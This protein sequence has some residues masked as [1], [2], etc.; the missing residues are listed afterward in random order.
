M[1]LSGEDGRLMSG[2]AAVTIADLELLGQRGHPGTHVSVFIPAHRSSAG[3][4]GRRIW[5]KNLLTEVS[6]VPSR[7]GLRA[8][9]IARLLA[10]ARALRNDAMAGQYTGDGLA[11]FMRPGWHRAFR[12]PID[13]PAVAAV[14]DYFLIGPLLRVVAGDSHFLLLALSRRKIRLFEGRM[15]HIEEIELKDV[16]TSLRHVIEPPEPRSDTM[17]RLTL[18]GVGR[19]A[20]RAVFY[21]HGAAD[22]H[23]KKDQLRRFMYQ[24]TDG[25]RGGYLADQDLPMVPVG[26]A[27][28]VSIYREMAAYP[29]LTEGAVRENPDQ[30][31]AEELHAA[32][33][34][35]VAEI[36][37]QQASRAVQRFEE[38]HGTGRT[39]DEPKMIE[40]AARQGR[41]ETLLVAE[42]PWCREQLPAGVRVVQL[43]ADGAFSHCELLDRAAA[44]TLS[45]GGQI[46]TPRTAEIPG[47]SDIAAVFRYLHP[48]DFGDVQADTILRS[49]CGEGLAHVPARGVR[50]QLNDPLQQAARQMSHGVGVLAVCD[51]GRLAG[52]IS[53]RDVVGVVAAAID[54]SIATAADHAS[55]DVQVCAVD[56]DSTE[57]AHH[58]LEAGMRHMAV[59]R[60]GQL[61]GIVLMR[62]LLASK[63]GR[64]SRLANGSDPRPPTAD[65]GRAIRRARR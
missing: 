17:A 33:W 8:R 50:M 23:F 51:H 41:V 44:K 10:P 55:R 34:P 18:S 31:S 53:E 15:Q 27:R 38:L 16:P 22:E 39:S 46:Y 19:Q 35:I 42:Q 25:L 40:A 65:V 6:A 48:P 5:W 29:H 1:N 9:D 54:V 32:A 49:E 7:R 12:V 45:R 3:V 57:V 59:V 60:D 24:V 21:G 63:C 37:D 14:G 28:L 56:D 13:L 52:V 43:G 62:D 20:G 58:M 2:A 26:Q 30:F 4:R 64:R 61:I 36:V 47:G 11:L